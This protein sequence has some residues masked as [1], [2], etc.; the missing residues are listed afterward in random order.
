MKNIPV[1]QPAVNTSH[2]AWQGLQYFE[3]QTVFQAQ[4]THSRLNMV[5]IRLVARERNPNCSGQLHM[6]G[7]LGITKVHLLVFRLAYMLYH[8]A[9]VHV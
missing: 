2:Q 6:G 8:L 5:P 3:F 7:F 1:L 9:V 4:L